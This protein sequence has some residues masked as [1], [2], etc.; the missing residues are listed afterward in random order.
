MN[1]RNK[2]L[3]RRIQYPAYIQFF[4]GILFWICAGLGF[5]EGL[6][7]SVYVLMLMLLVCNIS[8]ILFSF[9]LDKFYLNNLKESFENLENLNLKLRSQRHEYLNEM[10]IVYGLLELGEYNEAYNYLKPVYEDIAKVGKALRT[11]KPAV[12]ALLQ[13]KI[14][15][16]QKHEVAL[17]VEVSSDLGQLSVEQWDLCRVLGNLIDNACT[18]VLQN[19]G[20]K[21]IHV[22]INEDK[23][24]YHFCVYNNGPLIPENKRELIFKKGYSSKKEDGH[25]LGLW[26]VKDIVVQYGGRIFLESKEGKTEFDVYFPKTFSK[27]GLMS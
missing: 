9:L 21:S 2:R 16:S 7:I 12:N 19:D 13:A 8:I 23:K 22:V 1:D 5:F 15:Y 11:R 24:W 25:G 18:A 4:I 3:V 27:D 17:Y 10:Q 14:E 20:E 26:I 6:S